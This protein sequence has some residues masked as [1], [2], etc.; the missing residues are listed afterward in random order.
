MEKYDQEKFIRYW[1]SRRAG[2]M[3]RYLARTLVH[4]ILLLFGVSLIIDWVVT[5]SLKEAFSLQFTGFRWVFFPLIG[6]VISWYTWRTN[7]RIYRKITAN[8]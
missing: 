8:P 3:R 1:E 6:L 7:E 4:Y 5:L 2:G